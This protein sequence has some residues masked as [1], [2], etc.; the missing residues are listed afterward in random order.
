[1]K[2]II[3]FALI[4]TLSFSLLVPTVAVAA[5][6]CTKTQNNDS[7]QVLPSNYE[8]AQALANSLSERQ[9]TQSS[10]LNVKYN[11]NLKILTAAQAIQKENQKFLDNFIQA[12][13]AS[14]PNFYN[15]LNVENANIK[16]NPNM[17]ALSDFS[18]NSTNNSVVAKIVYAQNGVSTSAITLIGFKTPPSNNSVA[19]AVANT[20]N[21]LANSNPDIANISNF[22]ATNN[23]ANFS[24]SYIA[25]KYIL[26]IQNLIRNIIQKNP[27]VFNKLIISGYE[28]MTIQAN[29]ISVSFT[30][31]S[32]I[33]SNT[34]NNG[35]SLYASIN[36][37]PNGI[38]TSTAN[39][40]EIILNGFKEF[41]SEQAPINL[42]IWLSNEQN[43][44]DLL[45]SFVIRNNLLQIMVAQQYTTLGYWIQ[46]IPSYNLTSIALVNADSKNGIP[47]K[48]W[49]L[50]LKTISSGSYVT[51]GT[52][53]WNSEKNII[54]IGS[55][56]VMDLPFSFL[57]D[58]SF[59][60]GNNTKISVT[61]SYSFQSNLSYLSWIVNPNNQ[62]FNN[63]NI[64]FN[65]VTTKYQFPG[66]PKISSSNSIL[67]SY[68]IS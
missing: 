14:Y 62:S 8:I 3:K 11:N 54:P 48:T 35:T 10:V 27:D 39:S 21:N 67:P 31:A 44:E 6:S 15:S 12:I 57:D 51:Y 25:G 52:N 65:G 13:V 18:V 50:T 19:V 29:Q 46:N 68:L 9:R 43:Q 66:L 37:I 38:P 40:S 53:G 64:K 58:V 56:V 61:R 42:Q 4:S 30:S 60:G 34:I 22:S 26:Q 36:Y 17:V 55:A 41:T 63:F 23:L 45:K 47:F 59:I 33:N 28:P 20:I 24:P 32:P 7:K 49:Q 5:I 16:I 1:M 2:K